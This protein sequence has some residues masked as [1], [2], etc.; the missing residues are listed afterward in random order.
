MALLER[1]KLF[2]EELDEKT[3]YRY[4]ALFIAACTLLSGTIG[5]F[6]YRRVA[7]LIKQIKRINR[8]R[9][10]DVRVLLEDAHQVEQQR[11]AVDAIL[12]QD[13]DFKIA[14]YFKN[15]LEKLNLQDKIVTEAEA[16]TVEREDNYRESELNAKFGDLNMKEVTELLQELEQNPRIS[17]KR[18]EITASKKKQK[19]VDVQIT[20]TTLLPKTEVT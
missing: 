9:E 6:Y 18:L 10:E 19:T 17:T 7:T 4:A 5:F 2:I 16:T 15:L 1:I 11:A 3:F 12:S 8:L 14:G 20:I 13:I